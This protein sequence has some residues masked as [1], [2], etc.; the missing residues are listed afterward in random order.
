MFL[1]VLA[2]NCLVVLMVVSVPYVT[3]NAASSV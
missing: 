3:C 2:G 1:P